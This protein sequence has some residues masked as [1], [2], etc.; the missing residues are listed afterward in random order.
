MPGKRFAIIASAGGSAFLSAHEALSHHSFRVITDRICGVEAGCDERGIP[1]TRIVAADNRVFS[2]GVAQ[3]L[4][5]HGPFDAVFLLFSRLVTEPLISGL[6]LVNLHPAL[7][8]AYPGI[9][10]LKL[11]LEGGARF[12]G[13]TAH[14]VSAGVDDGPIIAQVCQVLAPGMT[15]PDLAKASF[16]HKMY[17]LLVCVDLIENDALTFTRAGAVVAAG[18]PFSAQANPA[19]SNPAYL[20]HVRRIEA[21]EGV[22]F[23]RIGA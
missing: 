15:L 1:R 2:G 18:R 17:L 9:G 10:A 19:L 6:P 3:D 16:L 8:P 5:E 12:F 23:T 4:K 21:Q 20:E 14:R 13:A 22:R 7:L 11:A